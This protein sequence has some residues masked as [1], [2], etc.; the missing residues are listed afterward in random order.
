MDDLGLE[1]GAALAEAGPGESLGRESESRRRLGLYPAARVASPL[2]GRCGF[3]LAFD[4]RC[5]W[6]PNLP[7]TSSGGL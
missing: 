7:L 4:A 5:P 3:S 2:I 1:V 6:R